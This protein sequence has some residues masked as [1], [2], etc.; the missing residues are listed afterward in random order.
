[1]SALTANDRLEQLRLTNKAYDE[2]KRCETGGGWPELTLVA[3]KVLGRGEPT[4][5]TPIAEPRKVEAI[6]PATAW[7]NANIRTGGGWVR[8]RSGTYRTVRHAPLE[9]VD[10]DAG[11]LIAGE[12]QLADAN[13]SVHLRAHPE[14]PGKLAEWR[15][16]E[17]KLEDGDEL[18]A[19]EIPAL[20]Q[21]VAVLAHPWN[22]NRPVPD[23]QPVLIYHVFWGAD[24][25]DPYALRR[26]FAR[27]AGFDDECAEFG[28]E[29]IVVRRGRK[30]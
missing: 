14:Q 26:L 11:P 29:K 5:L 13:T 20:Q 10:S 19:D 6:D 4:G 8:H 24:G 7:A 27:F 15:Y 28:G 21:R 18:Q 17:R 9:A 3:V 30:A 25:E 1:M 16:E 22:S 2:L 12:W 23:E